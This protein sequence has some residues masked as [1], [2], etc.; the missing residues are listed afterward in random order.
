MSINGAD[1][2]SIRTREIK[3]RD[4]QD[5]LATRTYKGQFYSAEEVSE[6]IQRENEARVEKDNRQQWEQSEAGRL[7][8]ALYQALQTYEQYIQQQPSA[9][10][11]YSG[12]RTDYG[13][14]N[15]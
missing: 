7:C 8:I 1:Q 13:E 14:H 11:N 2:G 10:Y 5:P 6:L 3:P 9:S 4:P 15:E 12:E